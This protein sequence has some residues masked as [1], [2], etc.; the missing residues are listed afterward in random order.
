MKR[1]NRSIE[2]FNVSALDLFASAMGAFLLLAIL[3]F[4]YFPNESDED[5]YKRLKELQGQLQACK[6]EGAELD[7]KLETTQQ[8][9]HIAE[10]ELRDCE[11]Q[12]ARTYLTI[13][14]EWGTSKHDIDLHVWDPGGRHFYFSKDNERGN[15]Y[16]GIK[17]QLSTDN[18][19][20]PGIEVWEAP[21]ARVGDYKI[22]YKFYSRDG[23]AENVDVKGKIY[24]RDG[25][26]E[27]PVKHLTKEGEIEGVVTV[28]VSPQMEV[29]VTPQ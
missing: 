4:P 7:K 10:T 11:N 5:D 29:I 1:K 18:T 26:K 6:A 15:D 20:G 8:E 21:A 28:T 22:S 27:F 24:F 16:P 12:E 23:N 19:N 9:K 17:D 3:M 25:S 14:M 13:V 2:I